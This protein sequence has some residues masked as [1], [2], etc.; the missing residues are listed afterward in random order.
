M[1]FF[2]DFL[3][4]NSA[5]IIYKIRGYSFFKYR[6]KSGD[7]G[8]VKAILSDLIL[9]RCNED[10]IIFIAFVLLKSCCRQSNDQYIDPVGQPEH[11]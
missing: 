8:H 4:V 11:A 6:R 1:S 5:S 3:D 2:L 10:L 7:N 9:R